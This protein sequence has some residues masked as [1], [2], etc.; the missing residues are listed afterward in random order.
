MTEGCPRP[1]IFV[2]YDPHCLPTVT[3]GMTGCNFTT[4]LI[5]SNLKSDRNAMKTD[6]THNYTS[7]TVL[8]YL[9]FHLI[10]FYVTP[11]SK[12]PFFCRTSV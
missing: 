7:S 12:G 3:A 9:C 8:R 5:S 6:S 2:S 11:V 10:M 1:L 4:C